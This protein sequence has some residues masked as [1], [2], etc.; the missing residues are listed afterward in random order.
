MNRGLLAVFS[1]QPLPAHTS[2]CR[3]SIAT[4]SVFLR[5][6]GE[7]IKKFVHILNTNTFNKEDFDQ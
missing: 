6:F 2:I 3:P 5:I 4:G 1:P 7:Y